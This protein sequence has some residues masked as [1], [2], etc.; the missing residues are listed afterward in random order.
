MTRTAYLSEQPLL[1]RGQPESR[2][3]SF[4][5]KVTAK[6]KEPGDKEDAEETQEEGQQD[7]RPELSRCMSCLGGTV[8]FHS[9]TG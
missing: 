2:V 7:Q 5:F 9:L 6:Q 1:L 4:G 8:I 3:P